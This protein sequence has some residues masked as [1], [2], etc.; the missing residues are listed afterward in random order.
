M[1]HIVTA[2]CGDFIATRLAI[3]KG[4]KYMF[5]HKWEVSA[6]YPSILVSFTCSSH[7]RPLTLMRRPVVNRLKAKSTKSPRYAYFL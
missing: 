1:G 6:S 2:F 3:A 7:R 4:E 5:H